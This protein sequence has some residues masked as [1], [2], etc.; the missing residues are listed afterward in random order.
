MRSEVVRD[1]FEPYSGCEIIRGA[2]D[3]DSEDEALDAADDDDD[4]VAS[5]FAAFSATTAK[6]SDSGWHLD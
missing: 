1:E 2:L 5:A 4:Y 6:P 3:S